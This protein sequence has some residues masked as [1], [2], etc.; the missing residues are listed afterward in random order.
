MSS[1]VL[2]FLYGPTLTSTQDYW[3]TWI[4]LIEKGEEWVMGFSVPW[5]LYL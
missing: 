3:E 5:V 1:L 4:L 2:S